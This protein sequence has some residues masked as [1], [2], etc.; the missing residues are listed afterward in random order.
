M[1]VRYYLLA[2]FTVMILIVSCAAPKA[3][4]RPGYDIKRN[5]DNTKS[6]KYILEEGQRGFIEMD[7][8]SYAFQLLAINSDSNVTIDL[9][10]RGKTLA[11]SNDITQNETFEGFD[12]TVGFKLSAVIH[13]AAVMYVYID[14]NES[15]A[16][17]AKASDMDKIDL[18]LAVLA[19][20]TIKLRL[21]DGDMKEISLP[22]GTKVNWSAANRAEIEIAEASKVHLEINNVTYQPAKGVDHMHKVVTL[23]EGKL[24][25]ESR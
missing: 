25:I 16:P 9:L 24:A 17:A 23:K 12:G 18:H 3:V 11:L 20:T 5:F 13:G 15:P 21:D 19:D 7:G 22:A 1:L 2:L 10:D 6:A 14:R 4:F 8:K